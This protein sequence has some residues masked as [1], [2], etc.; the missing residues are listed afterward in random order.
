M[1][2]WNGFANLLGMFNRMIGA[3]LVRNVLAVLLRNM[4]WY[5]MATLLGNLGTMF[6]WDML[7]MLNFKRHKHSYSLI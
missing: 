5:I 1:L 2:L 6:L 7:W 4:L 3:M